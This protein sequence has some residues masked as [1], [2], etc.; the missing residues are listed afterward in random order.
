MS[1]R[2]L[3]DPTTYLRDMPDSYST[4]LS[5]SYSVNSPIF[6]IVTSVYRKEEIEHFNNLFTLDIK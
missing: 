6:E 3:L 5:F 1:G 2:K 4:Q